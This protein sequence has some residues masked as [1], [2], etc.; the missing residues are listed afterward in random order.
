MNYILYFPHCF[1]HSLIIH[2]AND[3][4]NILQL[5]K[6]TI[7][8]SYSLNDAM[9]LFNHM[10]CNNKV[11]TGNIATFFLTLGLDSEEVTK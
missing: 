5:H 3:T 8:Y 2:I 7:S 10:S 11:I 9:T 1:S 6:T 4:F